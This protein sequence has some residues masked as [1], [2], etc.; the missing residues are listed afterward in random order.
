MGCLGKAG[1]RSGLLPAVYHTTRSPQQR[2]LRIERRRVCG[3]ERTRCEVSCVFWL[4]GE[5]G[6]G[7]CQRPADRSLQ[8]CRD[9]RPAKATGEGG[10]AGPACQETARDTAVQEE[11]TRCRPEQAWRVSRKTRDT[12]QVV[13]VRG[14]TRTTAT[15]HSLLRRANAAAK[16]HEASYRGR[17]AENRWDNDQRAKNRDDWP[18]CCING[19]RHDGIRAHAPTHC[20][21]KRND[22][23][24]DVKAQ[25]HPRLG[26]RRGKSEKRPNHHPGDGHQDQKGN[27]HFSTPTI[28][29]RCSDLSG[30][31]LSIARRP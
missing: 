21:C 24:P 4:P 13:C 6:R 3:H 14:L 29:Q 15:A 12:G 27:D 17:E 8:V 23:C 7:A 9:R 30:W 10:E 19:R 25:N 28:E 26:A 20:D 5:I 18:P 2:L 11:A 16:Q 31:T 22:K 1:C